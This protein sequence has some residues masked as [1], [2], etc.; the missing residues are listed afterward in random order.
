MA[1][2]RLLERIS[3]YLR[4]TRVSSA[5]A[6]VANVWF[7]V[8]WTQAMPEEQGTLIISTEPTWLILL[9]SAIAAIGLFSLSACMNDLID[10][11]RDRAYGKDRPIATGKISPDA[12]A[13]L[14]VLSLIA[15]AAGAF[16]LGAVALI[17]TLVLAGAILVYHIIGRFVPALGL[18]MVGLIVAGQMLVPNLGLRFLW[19]VWLVLTHTLATFGL[20]H[21]YGR[22]VPPLSARALVAAIIGWMM[23]SAG[24]LT[25]G[26]LRS[27]DAGGGIGTGAGEIVMVG[28]MPLDEVARAFWPN[29]VPLSAAIAPAVSAALFVIV[30]SRK[31]ASGGGGGIRLGDKIVRYGTAWLPAHGV[32]WMIGVGAWNQALILAALAIAGIFGMAT[33]REA[34]S[35][36]S[37]PVGYR[38]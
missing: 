5:F 13:H 23:W 28:P 22:K 29:W 8:L 25:L 33:L 35:L 17:L 24:L 36:S 18:A 12:G 15:A 6:A 31:I 9:C 3:P 21:V 14:A 20:A 32:A 7:V 4:V 1:V 38:L 37:Q 16:P 30:L 34:Y 11:R 27:A 26:W 19:P 10:A 2:A